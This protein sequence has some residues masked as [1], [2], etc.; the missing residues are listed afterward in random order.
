MLDK[1]KDLC[2]ENGI[3]IKD[4][5]IALGFSHGTIGHWN[6][7]KP[8]YD[9]L[10]LV[11]K[12]FGMTVHE[13]LGEENPVPKVEDGISE[14]HKLLIELFDRLDDQRQLFVI[15]QLQGLV[16]AQTVPGAHPEA[17]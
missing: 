5:E 3:T 14:K 4:L 7:S 9:K 2:K 12:Y 8:K 13:L 17:E 15:Q 1:I 10:I 6:K 16:L 11:A